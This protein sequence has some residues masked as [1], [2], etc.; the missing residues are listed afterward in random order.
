MIIWDNWR[1][2]S[3]PGYPS[4]DIK[5]IP[6]RPGMDGDRAID[7]VGLRPTTDAVPDPNHHSDSIDDLHD[8]AHPDG[9][10]YQH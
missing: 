6:H 1:H 5:Y 10:T 7:F 3:S 2:E 8:H 9:D 4:P